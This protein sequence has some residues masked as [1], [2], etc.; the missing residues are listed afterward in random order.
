MRTAPKKS[1]G[2][3]KPRRVPRALYVLASVVLS[4][5]LLASCT[6][7]ERP[8]PQ[9]FFAEPKPPKI[10]EFRWSNGKLPKSLDPA[11]AGAPPETDLVRAVYEGL[12][13][14]DPVTLAEIPGVAESWS[15]SEDFKVWTFKLR[16]EAR[17]SNGKQVTANDFVRAWTRLVQMGDKVAHRSL[18]SN[19]EGAPLAVPPTSVS[20]ASEQMLK[21]E[22]NSNSNQAV[23]IS[24]AQRIAQLP[25]N[26]NA[27]SER[28]P[29]V[30]PV[31]KNAAAVTEKALGVTAEDESTLR[32]TLNSPDKEF[33]RLVANPIFRP[34]FGTGDEFAAKPI[35]T[36]A[37]T[38]GPFRL[39][40]IDP[41]ELVLERADN[42]WG[43]E[44]IRLERVRMVAAESAEKALAAY[45]AGELDA[46]TNAEFSPLVLKLLSP[47]EDFRKTTHS[48]LNF[49]E[50]N[51]A[52]PPFSDRKVREALSNAIER[53]RLTET[54]TDGSTR[55]ATSFLPYS[56]GT[57]TKL[58]QDKE[59]A[60][61]LLDQAGF[62]GGAGFP[63]IKL[64]VNRN[65]T[66]QRVA[67]SVAR[68]WKQTLNVETEIIVRDMAD[69]ER[70]RKD[71]DF[72]LVRRGVVFPT[73]DSTANFASIFDQAA[74]D[75]TTPAEPQ[76][77]KDPA[78]ASS[79][80]S[81]SSRSADPAKQAQADKQATGP[82]E[83][84]ILTEDEVLYELRVIPLYFPTSY[85]LVKP[86]VSGF[87]TNS[88]DVPCLSRVVI[89]SDW[90]QKTH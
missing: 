76:A 20:D 1:T 85:S 71:G 59:K 36:D 46:I 28:L 64:V 43:R 29:G 35:S 49:Y 19:I 27:G 60:R 80:E 55:P 25:Q 47:Y 50:V 88:L 73:S 32:V 53:D 26:A 69:L 51:A 8:E 82:A 52:R 16:R 23:N 87:D 65:D 62:P 70:S 84:A 7:L 67:R 89:D 2:L 66:Q 6:Q 4:S 14:T 72:D 79:A 33:P 74:K 78:A 68:M 81:S 77:K 37:V 44:S 18:L 42:Y 9:P 39:T 63:V 17:W 45:R 12:T 54:E 21:S 90:Q 75:R 41:S 11:I 40:E 34:I 22:S 15:A 86:Y 58:T 57:K 3:P 13:E 30:L 5:F 56:S 10:Q 61:D 24:P 31:P 83:S 48:A 38:N